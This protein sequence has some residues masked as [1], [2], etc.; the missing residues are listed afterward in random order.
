MCTQNHDLPELV[1]LAIIQ[2]NGCLNLTSA[3]IA[4]VEMMLSP[5]GLLIYTRTERTFY[6]LSDAG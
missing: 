1:G 4:L 6:R 3:L 2:V 5:R